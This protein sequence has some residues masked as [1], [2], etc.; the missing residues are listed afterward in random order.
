MKQQNRAKLKG[1]ETPKADQ[2]DP[3]L[4]FREN[5]T[6]HTKSRQFP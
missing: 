3:E 6:E 4:K 1:F 5:T 2:P